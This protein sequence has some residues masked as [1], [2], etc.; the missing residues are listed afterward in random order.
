MLNVSADYLKPIAAE[1]RRIEE[2]EKKIR[3]EKE[4]IA[5]QLAEGEL[6]NTVYVLLMHALGIVLHVLDILVD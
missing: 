6:I 4:R 1:E 5:K 3:E 2:E